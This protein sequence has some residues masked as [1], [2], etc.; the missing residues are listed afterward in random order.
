MAK[1]KDKKTGWKVLAIA[2][3]LGVAAVIDIIVPDPV[4]F[5]DETIL[6]AGSILT[7][8]GGWLLKWK[9]STNIVIKEEVVN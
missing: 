9:T 2:I 5:I 4:P 3:V 1:G 6:I 8:L 7:F